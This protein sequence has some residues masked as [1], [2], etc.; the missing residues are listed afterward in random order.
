MVIVFT[1]KSFTVFSRKEAGTRLQPA[2]LLIFTPLFEA[3]SLMF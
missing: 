3:K 2:H 1:I